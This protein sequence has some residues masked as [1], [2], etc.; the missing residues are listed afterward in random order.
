LICL[1]A[2]LAKRSNSRFHQNSE[3]ENLFHGEFFCWFREEVA[4]VKFKP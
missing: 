4:A 1:G 3:E 2:I